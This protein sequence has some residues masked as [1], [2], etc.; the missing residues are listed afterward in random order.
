MKISVIT[1][2]KK[3]KYIQGDLIK[4]AK[5]GTFDTIIHGANCRNV[6]GAGIAYHI[7]KNFPEALEADTKY[8]RNNLD[9]RGSF[10][11]AFVDDK[12]QF[13]GDQ[14][15]I[16]NA[17]TQYDPGPYA[18]YDAIQSVFSK[19]NRSLFMETRRIGIPKIGCGIGGL[20]WPIVEL[21]ID[22]Y[23]PDLNITCVEFV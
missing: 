22:T 19:L 5:K 16:I 15:M 3:L 14:L 10:S 17:Y 11:F 13:V 23:A 12:Q 1:S 8:Y 21:I 9:F 6:M 2:E 7:A 18:S 4:E 20:E